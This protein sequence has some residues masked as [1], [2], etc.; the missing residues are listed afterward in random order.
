MASAFYLLCGRRVPDPGEK[1]NRDIAR[2]FSPSSPRRR[3]PISQP[4]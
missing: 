4:N 1:L 3:G 2:D